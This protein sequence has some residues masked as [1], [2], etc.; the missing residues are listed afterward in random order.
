MVKIT[1]KLKTNTAVELCTN[2]CIT[3]A[4][5]EQY[6]I[7]DGC[8]RHG[9]FLLTEIFSGCCHLVFSQHTNKGTGNKIFFWAVTP[10][11]S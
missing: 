10:H 3:T 7:L 2:V 11:R 9:S 4:Y 8:Q 5:K 1:V 6:F